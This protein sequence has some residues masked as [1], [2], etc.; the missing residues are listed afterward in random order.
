ML[1]DG[2]AEWAEKTVRLLGNGALRDR[3]VEN[4]RESFEGNLNCGV[5]AAKVDRLLDSVVRSQPILIE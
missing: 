1:A 3:M 2:L 4:A 5:A